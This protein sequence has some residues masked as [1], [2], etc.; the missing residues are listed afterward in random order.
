MTDFSTAMP[1]PPAA[2]AR[3]I[4]PPVPRLPGKP[5]GKADVVVKKPAARTQSQPRP[6][7]EG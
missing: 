6:S 7:A 3:S 1:K 2:L 4:R 5:V